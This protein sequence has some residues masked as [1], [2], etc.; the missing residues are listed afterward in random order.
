LAI[1]G[2]ALKPGAVVVDCGPLKLP[3]I[4]YAEKYLRRDDD[5]APQAYLVGVTPIISPAHLGDPNDTPAEGDAALFGGGLI[6][7]CPTPGAPREAVQLVADLTEL[8][9]VRTHFIDPAEHDGMAA[10]MDNL[11]PLLQLAYLQSVAGAR[12]WEDARLLGNQAFFLATYRLAAGDPETMAAEIHGN[13]ENVLHRLDTLSDMLDELREALR[14][15]DS[16]ILAEYFQRA[17]NTHAAW[18]MARLTNRYGF[19]PTETDEI[20]GS[21]S[22][23]LFPTLGGR[24][25]NDKDKNKQGKPKRAAR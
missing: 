2:P 25:K 6:V 24:G 1:I 21:F 4:R 16:A 17:M 3:A 22:M 10:A 18:Q 12:N 14:Q 23:N 11:P 8:L 15:D 9:G 19:E 20:R 5:G 7:I 13:R